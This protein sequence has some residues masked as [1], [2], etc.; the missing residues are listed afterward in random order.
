MEDIIRT[1]AYM[2]ILCSSGDDF[3][4]DVKLLEEA[5]ANGDYDVPP[6]VVIYEPFEHDSLDS[7]MDKV[8][9]FQY[10]FESVV[11]DVLERVKSGLIR[12]A[13]DNELPADFN[14]LNIKELNY[15]KI[16]TDRVNLK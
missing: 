10:S 14:N 11:N 16:Q 8:D 3:D 1:A 6:D 4:R 7:V 12:A 5:H 13:I 15:E 2:Q 9:E